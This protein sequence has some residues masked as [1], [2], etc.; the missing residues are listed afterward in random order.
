MYGGAGKD[1]LL[2]GAGRDVLNGGGADGFADTFLYSALTDSGVTKATRNLIQQF[3]DGMDKI[4]L[5]GLDAN[6]GAAGDQAF[7]YLNGNSSTTPAAV[8]RRRGPIAVLFHGDRP[9]HRG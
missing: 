7:T 9:G 8:Y 4:D 6:T 3:E 1:T 5:S 2:G